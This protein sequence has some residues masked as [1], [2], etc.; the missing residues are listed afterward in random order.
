MLPSYMG[1]E[2]DFSYIK[3][4]TKKKSLLREEKSKD[5]RPKCKQRLFWVGEWIL[6]LFLFLCILYEYILLVKWK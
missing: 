3:T 5:N 1:V 6:L 4:I 2:C